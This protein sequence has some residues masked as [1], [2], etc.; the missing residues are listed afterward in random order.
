MRKRKLRK[1]I[2]IQKDEVPEPVAQ[3]R[4]E[5]ANRALE[6]RP[7]AEDWEHVFFTDECHFYWG[8]EGKMRVLRKEGERDEPENIQIRSK[9]PD[10]E[11]RN[12][13]HVWAMVGYNFISP[14]IFYDAGNPNGKMSQE[15]Y[16]TQILPH[17]RQWMA[18]GDLPERFIMEEDNDSGHGTKNPNSIAYKYK[19]RNGISFYGNA[20]YS[21]DLA[22]IETCWSCPK[23][24]TRRCAHYDDNTLKQLILDGWEKV[25]H[26]MVNKMVHSMVKRM[27][28]VKQQN[29]QM[30][31]F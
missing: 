27:E 3:L 2:A 19:Q 18:N 12:R 6:Q 31:A 24:E 17:V 28:Y 20:A 7:D 14:L 23:G 4:Y 9:K 25:T 16:T 5:F 22:I 21:P 10:M 29:G 8:P 26:Y 1:A 15:C 13:L 30:T 11:G